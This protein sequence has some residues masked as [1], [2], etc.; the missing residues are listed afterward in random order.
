[1]RKR[2]AR[3]SS[4]A[5]QTASEAPHAPRQPHEHHVELLLVAARAVLRRLRHQQV[6]AVQIVAERDRLIDLFSRRLLL[7]M[8]DQPA[9]SWSSSSCSSA[10]AAAPRPDG[11][12]G[13]AR[14]CGRRGARARVLRREERCLSR[15]EPTSASFGRR[16]DCRLL[17]C[18]CDVCTRVVCVCCVCLCVKPAI[19][20]GRGGRVKKRRRR[21]REGGG[22]REEAL[23][24]RYCP[25]AH[26]ATTTQ[27]LLNAS[28]S[29]TTRLPRH[30][31]ETMPLA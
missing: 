1:V 12:H 31:H 18:R 7:Q 14:A 3:R 2:G 8:L 9:A 22:E 24:E 28:S 17:L 16:W 6:G 20:R 11:R 19:G 26:H 4:A 15:N 27:S 29:A 23:L 5:A 30:H 25:R 10:R 21:W 13:G